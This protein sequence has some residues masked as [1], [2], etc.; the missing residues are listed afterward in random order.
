MDD[1]FQLIHILSKCEN[2]KKIPAYNTFCQRERQF[3]HAVQHNQITSDCEAQEFL[4]SDNGIYRTFKTR[5]K[6]KLIECLLTVESSNDL[7]YQWRS[8]Y[9]AQVL[10]SY[11]L[12]AYANKLLDKVLEYATK[13]HLYDLCIVAL[14]FK[15]NICR[16]NN[17][18][19]LV[20]NLLEKLKTFRKYRDADDESIL[21]LDSW[22]NR[23]SNLN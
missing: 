5:L 9:L 20:K 10:V 18:Y 16:L 17:N 6:S 14:K 15:I 8:V 19:K 22:E 11:N 23:H 12:F 21:F 3:I 4:S 2:T 13:A 1:L 7:T